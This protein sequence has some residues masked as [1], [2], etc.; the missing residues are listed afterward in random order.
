M[1]YITPEL[2]IIRFAAAE[3]LSESQTDKKEGW[4]SDI[5]WY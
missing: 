4:E 5:V 2:D 1:R 3:V